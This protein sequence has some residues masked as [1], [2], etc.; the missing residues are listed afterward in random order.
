MGTSSEELGEGNCTS[1]GMGT[2]RVTDSVTGVWY[3][4]SVGGDEGGE[5]EEASCLWSISSA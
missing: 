2:N 3:D 4:P 1:S 5:G